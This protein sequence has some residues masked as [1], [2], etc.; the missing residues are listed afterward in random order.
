MTTT[1]PA[2]DE[3][4][5]LVGGDWL[6]GT[7]ADCEVEN[8]ATGAPLAHVTTAGLEQ[9]DTAVAYARETSSAWSG[10][11]LEERL[12]L[13]RSLRRELT[14]QA[15]DIA[16]LIHLE[17][18]SPAAISR[19][20]HLDLGLACIDEFIDSAST[21]AF[22]E[23]DG[24]TLTVH[25]APRVVAAIT[26]WNYPFYQAAIKV[27]PAL[28]VGSCVILKPAELTPLSAFAF[29][30][31]VEAAG[32][33]PGVF[34][35]LTGPGN[36]IGERLV[37]NPG[38]DHVSFT[39][40]TEV[41][42][43]IARLSGDTLT[44]T[45][46]ELGGKSASIVASD[47]DDKT[48]ARAVKKTIDDCLLNSGQSCTA[49]SRL[50]VPTARLEQAEILA[51]EAARTWTVGDRLGPVA[52]AAQL[53]SIERH[54]TTAVGDGGRVV[55]DRTGDLPRTGHYLHPAIVAGLDN[56][57]SIAQKEVFGP[58]VVLLSAASDDEA[59][60]IANDSPYGLAGAVWSASAENAVAIA[61]RMDAGQ[62]K[63][64]GAF[65]SA[66]AAFGGMKQSGV[67]RE[68]G[69]AGIEDLLQPKAILSPTG[70]V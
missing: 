39:G 37:L 35:L 57:H 15:D 1:N 51:A 43:R 9:V 48:F 45:T 49:L 20:L 21:F 17:L 63:V 40:S 38:I 16:E 13:L 55:N 46:L 69:R 54:I 2:L 70:R 60:E 27:V 33:P 67:G 19:R 58:V 50:V 66:T 59:V 30:R 53:E 18:G 41:G 65:P 42:R 56:Q 68:I 62:I 29:A 12:E 5:L 52:S 7:G 61:Q 32:F 36:V 11:P 44:R 22:T 14:E 4:L 23:Q 31:A 28:A 8:P 24:T 64:N 26:P 34:Q 10:T 47:C 3:L 25:Q 6:P